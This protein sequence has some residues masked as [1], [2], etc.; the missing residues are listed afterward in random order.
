MCTEG[1]K[2]HEDGWGFG[3]YDHSWSVTFQASESEPG[4]TIEINDGFISSD[5]VSLL[6]QIV[7][8]DFID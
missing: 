2:G 4:R 1:R 7:D 6:F 8:C 5:A 3:G